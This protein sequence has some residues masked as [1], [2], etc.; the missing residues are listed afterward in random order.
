MNNPP[1]NIPLASMTGFARVDGRTG[2]W[3]WSWEA[4]SVNGKGLDIRLRM[5]PGFEAVEP[6]ARQRAAQHLRRGNVTLNLTAN[7]LQGAV[8]WKINAEALEQVLAFLPELRRRLPDAAPSTLDGILS[9]RGILESAEDV[10]SVGPDDVLQA[11]L[12]EGLERVLAALTG[13]RREEGARLSTLLASQLDHIEQLCG[14]AAGLAATQP[15]AL[16]D[17]L[18]EQ[19]RALLE[20]SPPLPEDRLVQEV[21]LL[22]TKADVREELDRLGAHV[23]AARA[24]V[25]AREPVG[26]KLDFLCQEFNREAN[27]LCSK[28]TLVPLT[29]VGLDLKAAVEQMREQ[30]QNI[31]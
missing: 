27:T 9:L 19:L 10:Q 8:S 28:S 1:L 22:A 6:P 29:R 13:M 3:S 30:V 12:V 17:R 23:E 24:L 25:A 21:A 15:T 16:R 20:S 4:R 11:A 31:E 18:L 2:D 5:P 26:R 14:Q 7:R